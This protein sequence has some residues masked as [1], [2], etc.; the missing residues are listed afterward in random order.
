MAKCASHV[1]ALVSEGVFLP[2]TGAFLPLPKLATGPFLQLWEKPPSMSPAP[3]S[4]SSGLMVG[5]AIRARGQRARR[6]A[7]ATAASAA[8]ARPITAREVRAPLRGGLLRRSFGD[9]CGEVPASM[10][11]P[12]RQPCAGTSHTRYRLGQ[13]L[14]L[15]RQP[16]VENP[17]LVRRS[18]PHSGK[19]RVRPAFKSAMFLGSSTLRNGPGAFLVRDRT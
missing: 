13:P 16:L 2:E 3:E 8:P 17:E 18:G 19:G 4:I 12:N 11:W 9:R 1:E 10:V 6:Q 15:G 5:P 14:N 7:P